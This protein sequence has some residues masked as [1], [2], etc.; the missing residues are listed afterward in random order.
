MNISANDL[1]RS[2]IVYIGGATNSGSTLLDLLLG[3]HPEVTGGGE[4]HRLMLNPESRLCSCGEPLADC[5]YWSNIIIGYEE[6]V[7]VQGPKAWAK[8][9]ITYVRNAKS[10]RYLPN[11]GEL[12]LIVGNRHLA[13][14]LSLVS[15]ELDYYLKFSRNSWILTDVI[16]ERTGARYVVDSTK[17]AVRLK[18]LYI[19]RPGAFFLIHLVRD[20]RGVAASLRRRFGTPIIKGAARWKRQNKNVTLMA[21]TIPDTRILRVRYEDL[22]DDPDGELRCICKF[23]GLNYDNTMLLLGLRTPHSV[24][25]N[26]ML[27]HPSEKIIKDE[28]W[29]GELSQHDLQEFEQVAGSLLEEFGYSRVNYGH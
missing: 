1:P 9:P 16:V 7:G 25:G 29:K 26:P 8:F 22:C 24:P 12:A 28:R 14:S 27:F 18:A 3:N 20:G 17:T 2:K 23:V 4:L 13:R 19:T 15:S 6:A 21:R 10:I 5:P 11:I